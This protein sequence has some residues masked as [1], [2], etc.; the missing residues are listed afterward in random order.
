MPKKKRAMGPTTKKNDSRGYGPPP[1][2]AAKAAVMMAVMIPNSTTTKGEVT[3]HQVYDIL[4]EL[5]ALLP[6]PP[7]LM[8]T[9]LCD[10]HPAHSKRWRRRVELTYDTL[11]ALGFHLEQIAAAIAALGTRL[12]ENDRAGLDWLCS[13]LP[14]NELPH[15]FTE[16]D[17]R[18]R[19]NN[20]NDQEATATIEILLSRPPRTG[21][22][23]PPNSAAESSSSSTVPP[24]GR[25]SPPPPEIMPTSLVN[26]SSTAPDNNTEQQQ[27]QQ[28]QE[29]QEKEEAS[30]RHKEWIMSQYQYEEEVE[31][32]VASGCNI[33]DNVQGVTTQKQADS[34]IIASDDPT[35]MALDIKDKLNGGVAVTEPEPLLIVVA[36]EENPTLNRLRAELKELQDDIGN[37]ANNYMRSK[38]EV[39]DL[40]KRLQ[41]LKGQVSKLEVK[42]EQKRRVK[43]TMQSANDEIVAIEDEEEESAAAVFDLFGTRS[44]S[45]V[46]PAP[47][48]V[49]VVATNEALPPDPST[50]IDQ[51]VENGDDFAVPDDCIPK[52]WTGPTPRRLL[53]DWCK[54]NRRLDRPKF[55]AL[56]RKDGCHLSIKSLD[57]DFTHKVGPFE[58]LQHL[59]AVQALYK[60][61]PSLQLYL[62]FPPYFRDQWLRWCEADRLDKVAT[63]DLVNVERQTLI[64]GLVALVPML[65]TVDAAV[66]ANGGSGNKTDTLTT[67][68][69]TSALDDVG[70]IDVHEEWES[71]SESNEKSMLH[72]TAAGKRLQRDWSK[73]TAE[74]PK[75]NRMLLARQQLP[76]H[77][78]QSQILDLVSNNPVTII[79]AETGS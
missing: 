75:Y 16:G 32:S 3:T 28:Q 55:R 29:Q 57:I 15:V 42:E 6:P 73:H 5:A 26:S 65:K 45:H 36:E 52:S 41:S 78:F 77:S 62:R 22:T 53:E 50:I 13:T 35:E 24:A 20:N 8:P 9:P 4:Q 1:P 33:D 18:S 7:V 40:R 30:R 12:L 25:L 58:H 66:S 27:Q 38:H 48:I 51:N 68:R 11:S 14:M 61:D 76:I 67:E 60:I 17:V 72:P 31:V 74:S 43:K 47:N 2:I 19:W 64:D 69:T 46:H 54:Q 37:D 39:K 44:E 59:L 21:T 56:H 79:C 34:N 70:E 23:K 63:M 71:T 10:T 49:A